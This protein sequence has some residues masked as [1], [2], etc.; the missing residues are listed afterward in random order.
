M[1]LKLIEVR[2]IVI[3]I[4]IA[5]KTLYYKILNNIVFV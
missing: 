3:I 2:I 5:P 4:Q 1:K